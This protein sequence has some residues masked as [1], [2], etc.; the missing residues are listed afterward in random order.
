MR[1]ACDALRSTVRRM[2][3]RR[4]QPDGTASGRSS[5]NLLR[6]SIA[7]ERVLGCSPLRRRF[8][9]SPRNALDRSLVSCGEAFP[10]HRALRKGTHCSVDAVYCPQSELLRTVAN[11]CATNKTGAAVR[12]L[13]QS[14]RALAVRLAVGGLRVLSGRHRAARFLKTADVQALERG[15]RPAPAARRIGLTHL[16]RGSNSLGPA[17][18]LG[19]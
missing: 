4:P 18:R 16:C 3:C 13:P 14:A 1:C 9:Y 7:L 10:Q 11:R 6:R 12:G 19:T 5:L 17:R 15:A 8:H 2:R